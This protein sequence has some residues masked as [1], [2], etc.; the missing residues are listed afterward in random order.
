MNTTMPLNPVLIVVLFCLGL[1]LAVFAAVRSPGPPLFG[2]PAGPAKTLDPIS[3]S[4]PSKMK[5]Y[6]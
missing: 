3:L 4:D 1:G 2:G 5:L 6:N